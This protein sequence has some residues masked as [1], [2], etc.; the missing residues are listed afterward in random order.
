MYLW[1]RSVGGVGSIERGELRQSMRVQGEL[2]PGGGGRQQ[3]R[4]AGHHAHVLGHRESGQI[5]ALD[6]IIDP[7]ELVVR[8]VQ[9]VECTRVSGRAGD[10]EAGHL[11]RVQL[12]G[13]RRRRLA[14]R[15]VLRYRVA[16]KPLRRFVAFAA[17]ASVGLFYL[18][19]LLMAIL[20]MILDAIDVL[21]SLLASR[22]GTGKR[23][24][25]SSGTQGTG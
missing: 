17:L 8:S 16:L 3:P 4:V 13:L 5:L 2:G 19:I 18:P 6:S 21:V 9:E 20:G 24:L 14:G 22:N 15:D 10:D 25:L 1:G 23:L 12:V 7:H 11:G